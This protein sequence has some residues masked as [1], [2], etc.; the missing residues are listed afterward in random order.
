MSTAVFGAPEF[1]A[2]SG[3]TVKSGENGALHFHLGTGYLSPA[4][5]MDAEEFFQAKGD[6]ELSR[7]RYPLEPDYVVYP[8]PDEAFERMFG[9]NLD[10]VVLR[11]SD[12]MTKGYVRAEDQGGPP[13]DHR[14]GHILAARAYFEAHP[15]RKP[16][17]DAK[18]GEAWE[19]T[20]T[21]L[22]SPQ[23]T[24]V[25]IRTDRNTWK[26]D[27]LEME[28]NHAIT[29]ARRIWPEDAS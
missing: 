26:T 13:M 8:N 6:A 1:R 25:A 4:S 16:W 11:E 2:Q 12:G 21:A 24:K 23:V 3:R 18:P 27:V 29:A 15:E 7:W 19:I 17:E 22:T 5:A 28:F 20:Y 9:P 10:L 14:V